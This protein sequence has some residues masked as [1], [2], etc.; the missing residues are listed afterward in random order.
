MKFKA[1]AFALALTVGVSAKAHAVSLSLNGAGASFEG[2]NSQV[3]YASNSA[4]DPV[5][6]TSVGTKVLGDGEITELGVP[7]MMPDGRVI[8]G[9]EVTSKGKDQKS[10]RH[11]WAIFIGDPEARPERRLSALEIKNKSMA[12][13]PV[14]HGDPY[15]VGD[16][17]GR[18]AFMSALG[19]GRD[20]VMLYSHGSLKCV[21]ETGTRTLEGDRIAVLSFGSVQIGAHGEVVFNAYLNNPDQPDGKHSQALLVATAGGA[22][23]IAVEG[24]SGP[25]G[26]EYLSPFGI[27]AA[28]TSPQGTLVAFTAKIPSGTALFQYDGTGVSRVLTTGTNTAL[29]P[30]SYLSPGRPGLMDDGTMAV[31]AGCA[32]EPVIFRLDHGHLNPSLERGQ[33]TPLGAVLNSFGDPVLTGTGSMFVGATDSEGR[34]QV[35]VLDGNGGFF[36]LGSPEGLYRT[37]YVPAREHSIFSGTLSVNPQGDFTYLGGK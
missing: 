18:I 1:A 23:E 7:S 19:R 33:L 15:P 17:D 6:I 16:S 30:V 27:P 31:L 28:I 11:P 24:R 5:V 8:F 3:V 35:F 37:Q 10:A 34:E 36:E 26:A 29:G 25:N 22:S 12:C 32:R 9:A 21:A 20:G 14:F 2:S 13:D 4:G